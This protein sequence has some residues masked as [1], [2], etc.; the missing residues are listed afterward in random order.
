MTAASGTGTRCV[1]VPL[2]APTQH[3]A[4]SPQRYLSQ[5]SCESSL[6]LASEISSQ[7]FK[8]WFA[9]T[10]ASLI[11]CAL[12]ASTPLSWYSVLDS[13]KN[14]ARS[15]WRLTVVN[16]PTWRQCFTFSFYVNRRGK[17]INKVK[18]GKAE[19][20]SSIL[21]AELSFIPLQI[22]YR[23]NIYVN[24]LSAAIP[25]FQQDKKEVFLWIISKNK[26]LGVL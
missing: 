9:S 23:W 14:H 11:S 21:K 26:A 3:P 13:A 2:P 8:S 18:G 5:S 15:Y 4:A 19:L 24:I 22:S 20:S 12:W 7:T 6:C 10:N 25:Q 16:G 1:D 17:P